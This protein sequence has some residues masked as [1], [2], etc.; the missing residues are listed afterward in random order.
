ML[1]PVRGLGIFLGRP[2]L[3]AR[4]L[5]AVGVSW[6]IMVAAA[7]AVSAAQFPAWGLPWREYLWQLAE[8]LGL[9]IVVFLLLW[10]TI[11]PLVLSLALEH[12]AR[13]VQR[14]FGAEAQEESITR[15]LVSTMQV[16]V[17]TL[18]LRA[19]WLAAS[20][21]S[22]FLPQPLPLIVGAIALARI[23]VIDAVDIGLAVRGV[24]GAKRLALMRCHRTDMRM[25]ATMAAVLNVALGLTVIGWLAWFPAL[26]CGAARMV[27]L[28]P[29]VSLEE[30]KA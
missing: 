14:A 25:G 20:W 2:R 24:P 7:I 22:L 3:W 19:L 10:T 28:W 9:G 17:G 5:I 23:G 4:P 26:V 8:A 15:A 27:L 6:T 29:D 18:P 16:V 21:A 30:K 12:L 1:W 11:V 13:S